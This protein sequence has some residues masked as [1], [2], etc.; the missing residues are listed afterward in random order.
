[1]HGRGGWGGVGGGGGGIRLELED[2]LVE[3]ASR[4][5]RM[6]VLWSWTQIA[7][8]KNKLR[9]IVSIGNTSNPL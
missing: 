3:C 5:R 2:D 7:R 9:E 1:M 6:P 4:N 8:A